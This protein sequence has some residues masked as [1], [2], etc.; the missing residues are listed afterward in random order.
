MARE[1]ALQ[2]RKKAV[3]GGDFLALAKAY[4]EDS[5]FKRNGGQLG[6]VAEADIEEGLAKAAFALKS[7]GEI[8]EPV[9]T[10]NGFHLL[11]RIDYKPSFKKKYEDVKEQIIEAELSKI[12]SE[13]GIKVLDTYRRSPETEWNIPG[14]AALRT[15]IPREEIARKQREE[16]ER[17]KR[18]SQE[19][20]LPSKASPGASPAQR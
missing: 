12:R 17:M 4:S 10:R 5:G 6:F 7:N 19:R 2:I 14:I 20:S 15:E 1:L 13:A 18:E 16:L 8:S 9:E 3:D 11:K